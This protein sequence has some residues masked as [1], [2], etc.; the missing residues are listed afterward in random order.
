MDGKLSRRL[1]N[2]RLIRACSAVLGMAMLPERVW[3]AT[4][5][6]YCLGVSPSSASGCTQQTGKVTYNPAIPSCV[7]VAVASPE[8]NYVT[9][10]NECC[11]LVAQYPTCPPTYASYAQAY[12]YVCNTG[13]CYC[14]NDAPPFA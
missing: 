12:L 9:E 8:G 11:V 4:E 3:A 13:S 7:T 10:P 5:I 6:P 14:F 1:F 2:S